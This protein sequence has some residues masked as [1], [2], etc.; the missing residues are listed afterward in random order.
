MSRLR[1]LVNQLSFVLVFTLC[2]KLSQKMFFLVK[3]AITPFKLDK[4]NIFFKENKG[5]EAALLQMGLDIVIS[6]NQNMFTLTH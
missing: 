6:P 1:V 5:K 4:F 2:N 3:M